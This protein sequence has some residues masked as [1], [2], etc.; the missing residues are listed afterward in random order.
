LNYAGREPGVRVLGVHFRRRIRGG[1]D[2]GP[3]AVFAFKR[4]GYKRTD[5]SV[6]DTFAALSFPGFW[7]MAARFW[8]SGV[9]ESYRSVRKSAFVEELQKMV[10]EVREQDLR[11][12]GSGVRAQAITRGGALVDDFQFARSGNLL[13]LYNVPSPAATASLAIGRTI[14]QMAAES[15]SWH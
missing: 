7:R 11:P 15:F 10:P 13:H 12:G 1:V 14:V 6:P 2:A 8:R 3:N 5:F 4:E 9:G